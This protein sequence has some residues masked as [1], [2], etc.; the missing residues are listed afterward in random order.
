MGK[1]QLKPEDLSKIIIPDYYTL[2]HEYEESHFKKYNNNEINK[3]LTK[4]T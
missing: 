3:E 4:I 1:L 2:R